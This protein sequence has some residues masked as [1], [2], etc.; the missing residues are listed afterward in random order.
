MF[1]NPSTDL[2]LVNLRFKVFCRILLGKIQNYDGAGT[3]YL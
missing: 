2:D 3:L 1:D